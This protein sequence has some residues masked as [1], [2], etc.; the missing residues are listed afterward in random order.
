VIGSCGALNVAKFDANAKRNV[1]IGNADNLVGFAH[2]A[3]SASK[4]AAKG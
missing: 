2:G 3:P 4:L 1:H